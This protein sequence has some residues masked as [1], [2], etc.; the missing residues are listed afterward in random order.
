MI[1][2]ALTHANR[3][4]PLSPRFA[5]AFDFLAEF[6]PGTPDGRVNL[7]GDHLYALVGTYQTGAAAAK[8]FESHRLYADI[9]FVA[10][11]EEVI[12]TAPL[13]RLHVTTP[14]SAANDAALYTGPDDTPLRL[15]AGDF[16]VFWPQD[17]HKPGCEAGGS[18]TVKKVVIKVRL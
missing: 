16:G 6:D 10:V 13:D 18:T 8:P 9:Q 2:D 5:A 11:G 14:Y 17:G 12:W 4:R 1:Y 7:D 15:R 3:Y